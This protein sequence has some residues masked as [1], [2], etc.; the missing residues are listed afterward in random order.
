[1]SMVLDHYGDKWGK[2]FKGT[3]V[4]P[5]HPYINVPPR[6]PTAEE[7]AEFYKLLER[8]REYDKKHNEPDCETEEKKN[9]ILELAKELGI[10]I[11]FE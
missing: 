11:K 6:V 3:P 9:K 10:S 8:A 7:I 5:L 1:M 4:N 2:P